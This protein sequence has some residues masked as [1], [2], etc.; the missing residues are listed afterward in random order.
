MSA[1]GK[2]GCVR[3]RGCRLPCPDPIFP[4]GREEG[5][6]T[7]RVEEG[8]VLVGRLQEGRVLEVIASPQTYLAYC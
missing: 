3:D 1:E 5:G 2:V 4:R 7:E 6:P 8:K